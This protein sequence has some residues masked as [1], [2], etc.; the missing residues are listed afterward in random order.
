MFPAVLELAKGLPEA[1]RHFKV[2]QNE[3]IGQT[4]LVLWM[5]LDRRFIS[6]KAQDDEIVITC[7]LCQNEQ[8]WRDNYGPVWEWARWW[9][10]GPFGLDC[11]TQPA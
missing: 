2:S 8:W 6:K 9:H 10:C 11:P 5:A 1:A 7:E 3:A 4:L